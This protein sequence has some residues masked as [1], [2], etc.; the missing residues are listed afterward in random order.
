V[1]VARS[2]IDT[3]KSIIAI[4]NPKMPRTHGDGMIHINRIEKMVWS[5][6]DLLTIDYGAKV[7]A[8][9]ADRKKRCGINR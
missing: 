1:D 3:A 4:V 7:G 8:E 5:E 6:E 9:N 2:A